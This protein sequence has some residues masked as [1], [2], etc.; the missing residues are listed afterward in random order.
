MPAEEFPA[1]VY[2]P[3]SGAAQTVPPPMVEKKEPVKEKSAAKPA[4]FTTQV[5]GRLRQ[6]K[7]LYE[8]WLLTDDFYNRKVAECE[9]TMAD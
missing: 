2:D 4:M 7:L 8:E 9:A 6:L 5:A 1:L 3:S